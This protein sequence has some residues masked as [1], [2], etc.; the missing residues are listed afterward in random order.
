MTDCSY[1]YS[2]KDITIASKVPAA[3]G[4]ALSLDACGTLE[5]GLAW[6]W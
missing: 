5:M 2:P 1:A 4:K 6:D 3:G